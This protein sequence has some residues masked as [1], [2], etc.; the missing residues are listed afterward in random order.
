[1]TPAAMNLLVE[2]R[3]AG[4]E[5]S[6]SHL[7]GK[8]HVQPLSALTA[9]HRQA[10]LTHKPAILAALDLEQRI[11]AMAGRW[12]YTD[13]DLTHALTEALDH[14]AWWLACVEADEQHHDGCARAGVP[15]ASGGL[16]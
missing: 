6:P 13:D 15:S 7:P 16:Q 5:V 1:M 3:A 11:L 4:M 12:Q 10:I 8:V 2:L 14:P 9:E